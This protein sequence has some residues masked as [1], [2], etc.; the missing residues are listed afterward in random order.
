MS[1]TGTVK[2]SWDSTAKSASI[3][4]RSIPFVPSRNSANA[5]SRVAIRIACSRETASAGRRAEVMASTT[6]V[7]GFGIASEP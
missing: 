2:G 3:P 5:A 4:G 1:A 7:H 6:F